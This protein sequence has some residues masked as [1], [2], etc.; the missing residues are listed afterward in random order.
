MTG[1]TVTDHDDVAPA[2][3]GG[4]CSPYVQ[5]CRCFRSFADDHGLR[6]EE[7]GALLDLILEANFGS[8][9]ISPLTWSAASELLACST[10]TAK[11]RLAVLEEAGLITC[12]FPQGHPGFVAVDCYLD[13]VRVKPSKA[14]D[15]HAALEAARKA[16]ANAKERKRARS[17]PEP[18]RYARP[19][20]NGE[21]ILP[22]REMPPLHKDVEQRPAKMEDHFEGESASASSS[23]P[24]S[25]KAQ[26]RD[27][28][29]THEREVAGLTREDKY[30]I[31]LLRR[32]P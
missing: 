22:S 11:K 25:E 2:D 26:S 12:H 19:F 7:R 30:D 4:D 21:R 8:G 18:S 3:L 32:L 14:H 17:T 31:D 24:R 9:I 27:L 16:A 28:T 13:V 20:V 5:L 1:S 23:S 6:A 10:P 15:I 29:L